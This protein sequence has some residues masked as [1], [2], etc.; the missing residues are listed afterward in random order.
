MNRAEAYLTV[1]SILSGFGVTVLMFRIQRELEVRKAYPRWP[2]WLAWADYLVLAAILLSLL[3]VVLPI[4]AMGEPTDLVLNV[5]GGAC[6]AAAIMLAA[7][8]IAI[9]DHYRIEIGATR[10]GD[11]RKGEP[12]ERKVVV[13]ALILAAGALIG[14]IYYGSKVAL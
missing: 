8:P 10:R 9:L 7:Y 1:A 6:A 13:V 5:A 12:I 14:V 4:V 2:N 3:A 11:R